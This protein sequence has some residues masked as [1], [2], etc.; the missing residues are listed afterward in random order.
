MNDEKKEMLEDKLTDLEL[1]ASK[2][3]SQIQEI[4]LDLENI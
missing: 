4:R 2:L 3:I 1:A